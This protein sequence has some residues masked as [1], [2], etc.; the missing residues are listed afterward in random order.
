M[1]QVGSVGDFKMLNSACETLYVSMLIASS[2]NMHTR[3]VPEVRVALIKILSSKNDD[4]RDF[5]T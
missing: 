1:A 4:I 2:S 3:G 5:N